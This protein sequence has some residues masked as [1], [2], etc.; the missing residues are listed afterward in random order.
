MTRRCPQCRRAWRSEAAYTLYIRRL[1]VENSLRNNV[2]APHLDAVEVELPKQDRK[3]I[4][5]ND[6]H[7]KGEL[8][9]M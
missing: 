4:R 2:P 3:R 7:S 8:S 5:S 9:F 1:A 6:F